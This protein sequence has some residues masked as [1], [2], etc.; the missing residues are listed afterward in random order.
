VLAGLPSRRPFEF[1]L[2]QPDPAAP[3]LET[4]A[5]TN[6]LASS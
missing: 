6:D 3:S 4:N 2:Q 5:S 1:L